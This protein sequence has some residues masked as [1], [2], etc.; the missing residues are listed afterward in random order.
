V[1]AAE[2][3]KAVRRWASSLTRVKERGYHRHE[4]HP[5]AITFWNVI[6]ENPPAIQ[7]R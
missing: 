2:A 3:E 1:P 5:C 6:A 4:T 7:D